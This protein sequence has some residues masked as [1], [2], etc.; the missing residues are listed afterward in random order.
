MLC[1]II[2]DYNGGASRTN[3]Y[4][5]GRIVPQNNL[6]TGVWFTLSTAYIIE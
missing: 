4:P 2:G 3:I 6:A 1:S 5:D